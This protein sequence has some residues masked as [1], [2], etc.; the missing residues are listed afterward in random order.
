MNRDIGA[1]VDQCPMLHFQVNKGERHRIMRSGIRRGSLWV[2]PRTN[3]YCIAPTGEVEA[4][5]YYFL[6]SHFGAETGQD[7][8]GKWE[9][10]N[11]R[12]I[13]DVSKIIRR[14]GDR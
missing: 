5:M 4:L 9:Y 14:F 2:T 11:I 3:C 6:S 10:W 1:I 8:K 13:G 12:D 7:H